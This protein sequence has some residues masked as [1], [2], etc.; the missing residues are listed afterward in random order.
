MVDRR[1]VQATVLKVRLRGQPWVSALRAHGAGGASPSLAESFTPPYRARERHDQARVPRPV[2]A[3]PQANV[4][5]PASAL[6][7]R[8]RF[9]PR[10]CAVPNGTASEGRRCRTGQGSRRCALARQT[11][12][13]G[14]WGEVCRRGGLPQPWGASLTGRVLVRTVPITPRSCGLNPFPKSAIQCAVPGSPPRHDRR[15]DRPGG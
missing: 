8:R 6:H 11:Q 12:A 4:V 7:G 5:V 10:A 2:A 9:L 14:K 3:A 15:V 13:S 1:G